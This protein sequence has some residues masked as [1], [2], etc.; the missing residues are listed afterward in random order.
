[1]D[2]IDSAITAILTAD[3]RASFSAIGREVGLSTNAA[4]ARV[5][6]LE[7]AG[8]ILGYRAI[9]ADQEPVSGGVEAFVD[10]RLSPGR[11]SDEYLAWARGLAAVLDAAHV[12]GA[13]DFHLHVRVRDMAALDQLLRVLKRD[14]GAAQ[15]QTRIALR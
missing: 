11:D 8:V 9:L 6:R 12:T 13:Y 7:A 15:T 4:A 5:H 14:G 2:E 10:V 3:G 1:M